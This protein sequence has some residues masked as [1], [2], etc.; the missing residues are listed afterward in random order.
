MFDATSGD[1]FEIARTQGGGDPIQLQRGCLAVQ[2]REDFY[3]R[4]PNDIND[5]GKAGDFLV[6]NNQKM[7]RVV[8]PSAT[9]DML[10]GVKQ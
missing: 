5:T 4:Y 9:F 8:V 10:F 3:I 1:I 6:C 7:L 2:M